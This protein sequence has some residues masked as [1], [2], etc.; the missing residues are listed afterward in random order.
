MGEQ[1][2]LI[3]IRDEL[4]N[5]RGDVKDFRAEIRLDIEKVEG[6]LSNLESLKNR[7]LGGAAAVSAA[8]S[9]AW[10]FLKGD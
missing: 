8:I 3:Q 1:E 2:V 6:R 5:I 7:A 4:R 9:V 10:A